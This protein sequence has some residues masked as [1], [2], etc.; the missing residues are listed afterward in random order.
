VT[1]PAIPPSGD[2]RVV[3]L[4]LAVAAAVV[5]LAV[6]VSVLSRRG[7]DESSPDT[8]GTIAP[9]AGAATTSSSTP[10]PTTSVLPPVAVDPATTGGRTPLAGFGQVRIE[11][12]APDGRSCQACF[13]L[14]EDAAQRARGLM[15]VTDASLGGYD[16][17]LFDYADLPGSGGFWMRNT[18]LPLESVFF[19]LDGRHLASF[20]MVPCP[21]ATADADC[22][23]YGPDVPFG[24]VIE[25]TALRPEDLLLVEGSTIEVV[26]R[27]CPAR[28]DG[29]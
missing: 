2:R 27:T 10:G 14:A 4:L 15:E 5:V 1:E 8:P 25:L 9:E 23:R 16:G 18:R 21:D 13:L 3:Q 6:V 26:D 19:D 22:P 12:R 7:D 20:S 11:V 28:L 29:R 24:T 17:M